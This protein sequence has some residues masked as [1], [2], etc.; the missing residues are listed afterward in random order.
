[1]LRDPNRAPEGPVKGKPLP[2]LPASFFNNAI[3]AL[4][5]LPLYFTNDWKVC[6]W[7]R[8]PWS[9]AASPRFALE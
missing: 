3:V 6:T 1:M 7:A 9:R 4:V 8:W 2:E 5:G